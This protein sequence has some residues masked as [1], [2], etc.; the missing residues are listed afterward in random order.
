MNARDVIAE[1]L[2]QEGAGPHEASGP[3]ADVI[4]RALSAAGLAI[5]DTRTH[6]ALE[7]AD[8]A[9]GKYGCHLEIDQTVSGKP[10]D[11]VLNEGRPDA[12]IYAQCLM[13][14]AQCQ[15]WRPLAAE[16]EAKGGGGAT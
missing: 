4:L 8:L 2:C 11:C 1:T 6:V 13:H 5:I 9:F 16:A 12:C 7:M 10:D 14:P 15:Y 3:T